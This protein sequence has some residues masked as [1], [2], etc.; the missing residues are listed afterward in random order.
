[1]NTNNFE[2][3]ATPVSE[4]NTG[5]DVVQTVEQEV[6][7]VTDSAP[8]EIIPAA[9]TEAEIEVETEME[10]EV[11]VEVEVEAEAETETVTDN[12]ENTVENKA[13]TA[14]S[15]ED[16]VQNL[17]E[18]LDSP[19]L[20][21][22]EFAG[23]KSHF[24]NLLRNETERQKRA[25]LDA[26][27]EEVDFVVHESEEYAEGKQLMTEIGKKLSELSAKEEAE[28][29]QNLVK[30]LAIIDKIK[31][32]VETQVQEDFNK[33]YQEFKV[34]QQQWNDIK[35]VPQA[36][37][38][39]LWK[40]YQHYVEK[41]Y[42]L[43]RINNEF[44]EYDFKKNLELKTDLCQKAEKLADETDVVSAF[45]QLQNLHQE[46]RDI[47]P[48]ARTDREEIWERFKS[49]S[50]VINKKHQAHFES[51]KGEEEGNLALKTALCEKLEAI[52]YSQLKTVKEWNEKMKEV[53]EVQSEWRKIG[54]APK[55]MNTKVYERYRAAFNSFFKAKNKFNKTIYGEF[56]ENLKKKIA[57]CER[58]E[59]LKDSQEWRKVSQELSELQK[60]WK[61]IGAVSR[62]HGEKVWKR[63]IAACDHFF[64]Q[65]KT[66]TSSQNNEEVKNLQA[67]KA[68]TEKINQLDVSAADALATLRGLMDEWYAIGHV[69]FKSKEHIYEKFRKATDA[70]FSKLNVDK[71]DR[72]LENFK[73]NIAHL[74]KSGRN[75]MMHE[76]DKLVRQLER[77]KSELKTYENNLGFLTASSKKGNSLVDEINKKVTA[78]K[79]EF[80]LLVKKIEAIDN[81]TQQD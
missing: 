57:L 5:E 67:K 72:K 58:A 28:K 24:Y 33:S 1:M 29:E 54:Y 16:T 55:K 45:F 62:K 64:E 34:L 11:E 79:S 35:L 23:H 65:K 49:A 52:D 37:V 10:A 76:R 81:E 26:G 70:Q 69:P 18:L 41:F 8:E 40:S 2:N 36:K 75:Q 38:N 42:D 63:F 46:W 78:I 60:E 50:A 51:L 71:A 39:E 48:V 12:E 44:R 13:P 21:R 53:H 4:E 80:D 6:E 43:V 66:H 7:A 27:G 68:I 9:E 74:A 47:G 3:E 59:A 73:N 14:L 15:I 17:R 25:F 31:E 20:L 77:V 30:K 32:L 56:D 22:K 19:T 61:T